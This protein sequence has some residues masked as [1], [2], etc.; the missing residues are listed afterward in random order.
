MKSIASCLVA[1]L[2]VALIGL[3]PVLAAEP[4]A[5]SFKVGVVLPS[6]RR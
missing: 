3:G 1:V 2:A 5:G 6:Y 4:G